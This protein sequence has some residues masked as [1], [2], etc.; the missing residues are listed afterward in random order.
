MTL[1]LILL[2]LSIFMNLF[3]LKKKLTFFK[4]DRNLLHIAAQYCSPKI[5][6]YLLSLGLDLDHRDICHRA[7]QDIAK[8]KNRTAIT[9]VSSQNSNQA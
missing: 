2:C 4:L 3:K 6:T 7:P 5:F 1:L 9:K 8:M